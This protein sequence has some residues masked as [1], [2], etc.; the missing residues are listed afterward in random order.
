MCVLNLIISIILAH[1]IGIAGVV[2]GT[3]LSKLFTIVFL[4]S[5][6]I[7]VKLL[8]TKETTMPTTAAKLIMLVSKILHKIT[9]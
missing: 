5:S 1:Y 7:A 8:P 6:K 9:P 2:L 3:I 4:R